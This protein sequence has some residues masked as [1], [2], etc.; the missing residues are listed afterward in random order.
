MRRRSSRRRVFDAR[1][2]VNTIEL[3]AAVGRLDKAKDAPSDRRLSTS[4]FADQSKG[5]AAV[6]R[7]RDSVNGLNELTVRRRKIF[8]EVSDFDSCSSEHSGSAGL[9]PVRH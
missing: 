9:W 7:K 2:Q 4:R 6:N 8:L 5:F 3:H 1:E